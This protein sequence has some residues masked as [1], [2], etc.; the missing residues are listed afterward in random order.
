[1]R[2]DKT[3]AFPVL[4]RLAPHDPAGHRYR[5]TL[6]VQAP[7]PDGQRLS[8]PAWIPGSYLIRD[9][10]RQIESLTA[11]SGNRRVAVDKIDNHTW[12]AAPCDGPLRVEYAVY[13]WDLSVR[14][15]H[16]DETHGFFNGTSVFLRV[17]G[18]DHLPCLVDL[19]PPRG[20]DGWKV[21]TS[22]PEARGH[23]GAARRHGFG[24]YLA[25]DYDALIDH[26]VEM[27]TPQVASFTAHGAEHELVFTGVAP[28]LDL[29]RI[30]DDVRKICETQIA[31][32]EPRT[33][34]APFLDSADRYVFMTMVTGDGY[35]GLE[36]RASTALMT[37]RKDLP[38]LG[39]QGQGDGYRG[40]LGLVSHE[41]FHT[42]NV[43]RIKPQ[44]F[45]PY[46]LSQPDLSRLLWVFEG[47][48]SYYDD[49]LLLRST[50]IT[51]SDYLRLLAKTITSV[52]R[53][54][55]RHKQS[56]AESSF[57]AWTRYY[58]QDENSP[59]ALVSYYTKGALVAL[60]LDLLIRQESAGAYSLDDVMR[61]L[62]QRYGRDFYQGKPQGLP[63]DGL[64]GVIKEAT[65]VDARRFIARY[66]YGVADVPLAELLAPHGIKVQWKVS[67]NI[68]SLD[69]RTRKQG[70]SL[71]LATVLEG[72]AGH[73]GGLSAGDLLV[74]IDGLKVEG[75][76][77]V[78]VLLGQY[79]VGDRVDVHVFRRDELR[80]FT[81]KLSGPEALDCVL[82]VG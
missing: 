31:F 51:Q 60:G 24:R 28:N 54:P 37:A 66:A 43:K 23:Q 16:L 35:G 32:F 72:G 67:A 50:A 61:L 79:R 17:H 73:K 12:Q 82:T 29:A 5:I 68:P 71:V 76:A 56:V 53:T 75:A 22:L 13:A 18:Q 40:F 57:D 34:R 9:F 21:Y 58:K 78:E 25:P 52:A 49:L 7:S 42:W 4:Y 2:M 69:V 80:V 15:A 81:V 3:D 70:D 20:I 39:Q 48:T 63:E 47:F 11:Y 36:H 55:G 41:Y 14:G 74:A 38:V 46:D 64:P 45:V 62:W 30:T 44:A 77:G 65:G 6:T 10:S 8:L 1:M 27:G 26:P 19:A 33:K 59:N